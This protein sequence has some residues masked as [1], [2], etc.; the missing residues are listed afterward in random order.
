LGYRPR[1]GIGARGV[2][3][4]LLNK[5]I[6]TTIAKGFQIQSKP[7]PGKQ[8]QIFE[9][10][11]DTELLPPDAISADP[12]PDP[13]LIRADSSGRDSILLKGSVSTIKSGD[14]VLVIAKG[15]N[16]SNDNYALGI[17]AELTPENDPHGATNTRVSFASPL[18]TSPGAQATDYRLMY[19][20]QSAHA[21][22]YPAD[23]VVLDDQIDLE[24]VSRTIKPGDPLLFEVPVASSLRFESVAFSDEFGL[25]EI[26]VPSSAPLLASV[27]SYSE[28]VWFANAPDSSHPENPPDTS[29]AAIPIP[30]SRIGFKTSP[31]ASHPASDFDSFRTGLQLRFAWQDA[32][33]VIGTPATTFDGSNPV[34]SAPGRVFP[35][36]SGIPLQIEDSTGGGSSAVGSAGPASSSLLVSGFPDPPK[37]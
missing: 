26:Y 23:E 21:W 7:G 20:T 3:G 37:T 5:Q 18:G 10:D 2:V 16:A 36:G 6:T 15:W 28:V 27:T 14:E 34:L 30:H 17:V 32:G 29:K 24:S 13:L 12:A 22:Q 1:P 8:P 19:S 25:I 31:A 35:S 9:V 33:T 4:A 11:A